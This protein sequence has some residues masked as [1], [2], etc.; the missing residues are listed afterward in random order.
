MLKFSEV[1][2]KHSVLYY[3]IHSCVTCGS[4]ALT[5]DLLHS[6]F[7][8][9]ASILHDLGLPAVFYCYKTSGEHSHRYLL[10]LLS[11]LGVELPGHRRY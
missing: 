4:D 1:C 5:A 8:G 11:E 9:H 2:S 7:W 10:V 3:L 6:P